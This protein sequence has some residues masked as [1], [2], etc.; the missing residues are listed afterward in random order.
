MEMP[1]QTTDV[2]VPLD[3][4]ELL[5]IVDAAD[6]V[7]GTIVRSQAKTVA[8]GFYRTVLVFIKDQRGRLALFRRAPQKSYPRAW[9]IVGG[10]VQSGESYH[11]AFERELFEEARLQA[12]GHTSQH[13]GLVTP[14]EFSS[15][16]F[17]G[18]YE[19]VVNTETIDY[20]QNDFC[21]MI[22]LYPHEI[23]PQTLDLTMPDL[24]YLVTRFYKQQ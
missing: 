19:I 8:T 23:S 3:H 9:A 5:D 15:I 10:C 2:S 22:W 16:Y 21:Q 4:D 18:V 14:Q 11:A 13:L 1:K 17:K 6:V 24:L 12:S 7:V 20:E